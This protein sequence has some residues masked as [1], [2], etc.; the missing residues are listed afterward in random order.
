M[1]RDKFTVYSVV[2]ECNFLKAFRPKRSWTRYTVVG[3]LL[4]GGLLF[5]ILSRRVTLRGIFVAMHHSTVTSAISVNIYI[6]P[7]RHIRASTQSPTCSSAMSYYLAV[8]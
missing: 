6:F 5:R 4:F 1:S 2:C 8:A 7:K 3:Q